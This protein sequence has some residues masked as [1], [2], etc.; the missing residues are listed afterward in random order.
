MLIYSS[1]IVIGY[2]VG[3]IHYLRIPWLP[4]SVI[5]IA[6]AFFL[7]FK[8]NASYDRQWEARKIYGAI[9]NASR[10]WAI[11]VRDYV[12]EVFMDRDVREDELKVIHTELIYRHLAWLTAMRHQL[13]RKQTWEHR[14]LKREDDYFKTVVPE[15]QTTMEN[16]L[17]KYIRQEELAIGMSKA[18]MATHLISVQ[19]ARLGALRKEGYID[20]F[21]HI[22]LQD[23]LINLFD[24]QGKC[25]RIKNYPFPRQYATFNL[26]GV[27]LFA[28]LVPLGMIDT[29]NQINIWLTIPFSTLIGWLFFTM[30]MIGD[31]SENPFEGGFN[32][33]PITSLSRTIEVD[34]R[35]ILEEKDMPASVEPVNGILF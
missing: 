7:G 6:V 20:D 30:E 12:T 22:A 14:N 5:G 4:M 19:S 28:L 8:N 2:E 18:N 23:Q 21:R 27:W 33:I 31:Y 9:V 35:Q 24:Q 16:D 1:I 26:F 11:S 34:L 15:Y 10:S 32:D 25:E 17:R 13:R 3:H 29:F